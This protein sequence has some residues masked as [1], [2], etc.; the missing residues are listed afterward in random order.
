VTAMR[1]IPT[2][3]IETE[4][5]LLADGEGAAAQTEVA[6]ALLDSCAVEPRVLWH[7]S[8]ESPTFDARQAARAVPDP[9]RTRAWTLSDGFLLG[10]GAR[11]YVDLGHPE[12]CT[13]ECNTPEEVV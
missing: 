12:Y 1:L 6:L 4:Y 13:P 2:C 3:G 7:A 8:A 10:N 5:G 9:G 11:F